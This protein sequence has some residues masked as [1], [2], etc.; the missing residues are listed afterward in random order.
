VMKRLVIIGVVVIVLTVFAWWLHALWATFG[1]RTV[2]YAKAP[3]GTEMCVYQVFTAT[4]EPYQ[5]SFYSRKPGKSWGWF[6]YDHQ[7]LP[8]MYGRIVFYATNKV[9]MIYRGGKMVGRYDWE[10]DQ[11]T[12]LLRGT[13]E[14]PRA[15][16]NMWRSPP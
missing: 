3:D 6:Y 9:A 11:F 14:S 4:T 16:P 13:T 5:T 12:H 15:T 10:K 2:L 7:D 1:A 8:W